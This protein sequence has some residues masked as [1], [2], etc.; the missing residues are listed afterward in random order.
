MIR[1]RPWLW[2]IDM[3]SVGLIR[4]CWQIAPALIIQ[5]FFNML[6]GDAPLTFG[7]WAVVAF[8]LASWVGRVLASYGFYYADVPIFAEL[9]TL[10]RRN[11]LRYILRRPGAATLP[12][13]PGEAVSRFKNDVN[14]IPLF[15]ILI[16]DV[17][18]GLIIVGAAIT[19][20]AQISPSVTVMALIPLFVVGLIATLA[21][22]R[23][24]HYRTASRQ[25]TG[26]V[27]GFI[28]EFFGDRKSTR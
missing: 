27:T 12:D 28:G 25:A 10:L 21:T 15:V 6:T 24:E 4:F 26:K 9:S 17:L 13:S 5:A 1:F 19:L 7:I 23:I 16:N 2:L 18:V 3:V 11:L 8:A 22:S 14:E 20:M